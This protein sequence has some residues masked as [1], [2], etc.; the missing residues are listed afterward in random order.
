VFGGLLKGRSLT[1][2]TRDR[3]TPILMPHPSR[4]GS[5]VAFV[6]LP[7]F[8]I[9]LTLVSVPLRIFPIGVRH[10]PAAED[11]GRASDG[12]LSEGGAE[13]LSSPVVRG[14]TDATGSPDKGPCEP[15]NR[16]LEI[17]RRAA[18]PAYSQDVAPR[19][20]VE[21]GTCAISLWR[22]PKTP[23]GHRVVIIDASGK[24]VS[25]RPGM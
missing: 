13:G 12:S 8:L 6:G 2:L 21:G 16:V 15:R 7:A 11:A 10:S 18:G 19:M 3:H 4:P 24:V 1:R 5:M 25:V 23:G 20:E 22:I 14:V 9:L 17:A